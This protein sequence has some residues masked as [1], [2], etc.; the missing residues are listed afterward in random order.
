MQK[1]TINSQFNN[2]KCYLMYLRQ[3]RSLAE[4]VFLFE[5]L[6]EYVDVAYIN[7][8]LVEKGSIA[9]FNDEVLGLLALPWV[10]QGNLDVY[11]RPTTI[12]VY[13]TNG[14]TKELKVGEYVIM[15]D[16]Y[17]K[18]PLLL[19]ITQ[20]AQ[21]LAN[22][23]R[24]QDINVSQQ[25]TPRYWKTS[26]DKVESIK[27]LLNK[28]DSDENAVIGYEDI[29]IDNTQCVLEP[30]PYVT[31]KLDDYKNNIFN[32]FLRLIGVAN[33]TVQKKERNIKDEVLASQGGTIAS[34]FSRF[35]PRKKAVDLINEKFDVDIQVKFFD[36]LPTSLD[37]FEDKV[38][39][40]LEEYNQESEVE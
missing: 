33:L 39:G 25:K 13:G 1:K 28:I 3:C 22:C 7:K 8:T 12:R 4:N 6:P 31:D 23:V 5:N 29:D 37:T 10:R 35:E 2:F 18:Y 11:G 21:R 30:A 16:N 27:G 24:V 19:D 15:Y 9:W 32:E 34:R 17:G 38:E 20:Y 14:Y 36:G 26:Q 40:N